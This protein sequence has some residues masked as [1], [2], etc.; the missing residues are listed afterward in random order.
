AAP[1][2]SS[3]AAVKLSG[4]ITGVVSDGLG[5]R[6]MGATI[7]LFNRQDRALQK[8]QSDERGE[9]RFAGLLP[10]A[11][12]IRVSLATYLP[13]FKKDI[14]V[15]PGMRSVLHISLSTLLSTIQLT[16]PSAIESGSIMSDDWKWVL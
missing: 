16:Y 4:A 11:Y 12:S 7:L 8:I 6:Q 14:L 15:Q 1:S 2:I 3:A 10:D 5:A 9:F 13:A